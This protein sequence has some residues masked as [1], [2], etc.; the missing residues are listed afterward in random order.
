[1][2]GSFIYINVSFVTGGLWR[3]ADVNDTIVK[4]FA[5]VYK[6]LISNQTKNNPL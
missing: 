3:F 4:I 2:H 5:I 1:M 6:H